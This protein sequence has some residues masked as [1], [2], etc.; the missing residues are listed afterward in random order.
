MPLAASTVAAL[1]RLLHQIEVP[2]GLAFAQKWLAAH[3]VAWNAVQDIVGQ[4]AGKRTSHIAWRIIKHMRGTA[5]GALFARID[6]HHHKPWFILVGKPGESSRAVLMGAGWVINLVV[7][8]WII[9]RGPRVHR[10]RG[11]ALVAP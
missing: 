3:N 11:V 10:F 1:R 4:F 9:R 6:S 8:E 5:S 7:A 2:E